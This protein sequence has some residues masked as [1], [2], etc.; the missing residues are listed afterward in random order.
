MINF[1]EIHIILVLI[2]QKKL[3]ST[4]RDILRQPKDINNKKFGSQQV[5]CGVK[6]N[7]VIENLNIYTFS[8]EY[9]NYDDLFKEAGKMIH[10]CSLKSA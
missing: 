10:Q 1:I 8:G 9:H 6:E 7:A 3:I 2:K 4:D 5:V